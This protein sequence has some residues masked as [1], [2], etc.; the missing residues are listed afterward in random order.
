MS[1]GVAAFQQLSCV[2]VRFA[3]FLVFHVGYAQNAHRCGVSTLII[4][5][6]GRYLVPEI[7]WWFSCFSILR[8][9]RWLTPGHRRVVPG[10]FCVSASLLGTKPYYL[11]FCCGLGPSSVQQ[12]LHLC[13]LL[14]LSRGQVHLGSHSVTSLNIVHFPK[15]TLRFFISLCEI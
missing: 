13:P 2:T 15:I 6:Q 14:P 12:L 9:Q 4:R 3:C 8:R 1:V 10:V 11:L 5:P 7:T